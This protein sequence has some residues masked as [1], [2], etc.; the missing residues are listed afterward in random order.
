MVVC[1]LPEQPVGTVLPKMTLVERLRQKAQPPAARPCRLGN[2]PWSCS[3]VVHLWTFFKGD[4][5]VVCWFWT[6]YLYAQHVYLLLCFC[7]SMTKS[8]DFWLSNTEQA[9]CIYLYV[10]VGNSPPA[11][12]YFKGKEKPTIHMCKSVTVWPLHFHLPVT[13][14]KPFCL[15]I[16]EYCING[17]LCGSWLHPFWVEDE[18]WQLLVIRGAS[19]S[20][21]LPLNIHARNNWIC[22]YIGLYF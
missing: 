9:R 6:V 5:V 3:V 18:T 21:Y 8:E 13:G 16:Y 17:M 20:F 12:R 11:P 22:L 4:L 15:C 14:Q 7:P 2:V 1:G 19:V 10:L